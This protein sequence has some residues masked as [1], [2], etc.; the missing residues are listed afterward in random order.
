MIMTAIPHVDS[1]WVIENQFAAGAYPS[2]PVE[3][4]GRVKIQALLRAGITCFV[5][6]TQHGDV[7]FPY[8]VMLNREAE[9]YNLA[10]KRYNFPIVDYDIPG[11]EMMTDI[12]NLIDQNLASGKKIYV[13][14]VGGVGRTG[15]VVGCYLVRHGL[16]GAAALERITELRQ[17]TDTAW[18][19]SPESDFQINFVKSWQIGQ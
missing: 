5:D 18:K 13:H 17:Q 19:N 15:T 16:T 2:S 14:C 11:E 12:L 7:Y 10:A 3:S 1:Y 4:D 6:L 8:K 9:E